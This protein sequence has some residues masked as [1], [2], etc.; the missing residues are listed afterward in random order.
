MTDSATSRPL[1]LI[2]GEG[3]FPILVAK[4]A[5]AAGRRVV[6]ASLGGFASDEIASLVDVH[7]S[8]GL[9]RIGQWIRVMHSH[10]VTEAIMVG[11][12]PKRAMYAGGRIGR[13]LQFVPDF[14]TISMYVR[15]VRRDKRD[16]AVLEALA[17]ELAS[18]GITLIDSTTFVKDHLAQPGVMTRR[19]PTPRQLEDARFGYALGRNVS[20]LDIGQSL[21]LI[22]KD[23]IA[24]EAIEGTDAMIRRAGELCRTRGWTMIKVGNVKNDPR[25]DVPV[26]GEQTIDRLREAGCGCLA[27]EAGKVM[28]LDR[29]RVLDAADRAGI[30]VVGIE[31]SS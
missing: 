3:V 27:L 12:V 18:A 17:D 29:V 2:A 10:G 9:M 16:H 31:V 11:R 19:Q 13:W 25:F 8:V 14:R 1:G 21:A 26:V 20:N 28:M 15:R 30:A 22:D 5:R 6:C 23:V 4:G 7:H 24:V